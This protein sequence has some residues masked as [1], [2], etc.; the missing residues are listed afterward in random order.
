MHVLP[1]WEGPVGGGPK[2][3]RLA[4]DRVKLAARSA[5]TIV[6]LILVVI[7]IEGFAK[8]RFSE[9]SFKIRTV[10]DRRMHKDALD[11]Y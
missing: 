10:G 5:E 4:D 2:G 11:K 3:L 6:D 8:R 1:L 9:V 7:S